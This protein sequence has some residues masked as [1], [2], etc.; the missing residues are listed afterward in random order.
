MPYPVR[1]TGQNPYGPQ[2]EFRTEEVLPPSAVYLGPDDALLLEVRAPSVT[3]TLQLSIRRLTPDGEV[4][5]ELYSWNVGTTGAA[6]QTQLIPPAEGYILSAHV[7]SD[8]PERGQVFVK[9]H[10]RHNLSGTDPTLGHLFL[11]GYVTGDDHLGFPQSPTE[12]SISG[13]GWLHAIPMTAGTIPQAIGITVPQGVRWLLRT[14]KAQL[15]T[16]ATAGTRLTALRVIEAATAQYWD[17]PVAGTQGPG[18][19]VVYEWGPGLGLI[20]TADVATGPTPEELLF[21]PGWKVQTHTDGFDTSITPDQWTSGVIL[22]EEY[23]AV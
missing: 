19:N 11:Q 16:S 20:Q 22:V 9:L 23:A 12:S 17:Y 6:I 21:G 14:F 15:L 8:T 5:A 1:A 2:V 4:T 7:E 10:A 3:A 18:L 13:R